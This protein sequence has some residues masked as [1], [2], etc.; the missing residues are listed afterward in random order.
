MGE[1]GVRSEL[2]LYRLKKKKIQFLNGK[3]EKYAHHT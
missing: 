2:P 3:N 1:D